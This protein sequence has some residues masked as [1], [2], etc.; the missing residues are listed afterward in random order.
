[1]WSAGGN[2][3]YGRG[4]WVL[5]VLGLVAGWAVGCT[6]WGAIKPAPESAES[7]DHFRF[8]RSVL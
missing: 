5:L 1:M 2:R 7:I 8:N 3:H 6:Q 4:L